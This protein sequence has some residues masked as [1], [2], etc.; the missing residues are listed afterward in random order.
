MGCPSKVA[1]K[2]LWDPNGKVHCMIISCIGAMV[3][4]VWDWVCSLFSTHSEIRFLSVIIVVVAVCGALGGVTSALCQVLLS[5][6]DNTTNNGTT[7]SGDSLSTKFCNN[8]L[9]CALAGVISAFCVIMLCSSAA[10]FFD[11]ADVVCKGLSIVSLSLLSGFFALRILPHLG[12]RLANEIGAVKKDTIDLRNRLDEAENKRKQSDE[13]LMDALAQ[14]RETEKKEALY[15]LHS[16]IVSKSLIALVSK[17]QEDRKPIL[18]MIS[19]ELHNFK[20]DRPVNILYGRLLRDEA[21][22]D[23]AICVLKTFINNIK[24]VAAEEGRECSIEERKAMGTAYF[25]IA[26]YF[27]N[28]SDGKGADHL[29]DT[30]TNLSL[31][32]KN[33]PAYGKDWHDDKDLKE[34]PID[35][36]EI[37][38]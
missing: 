35:F 16:N 22:E 8:K 37:E 18:E 3:G 20:T 32:I 29:D 19:N 5:D 10:S 1:L 6:D 9:T 36:I 33:V 15:K 30:R 26:C 31:A 23:D 25:N 4:K 38:K 17:Q 2:G 28:R 11:K 12:N 14:L 24:Q 34:L 13:K 7:K 27:N 21:K